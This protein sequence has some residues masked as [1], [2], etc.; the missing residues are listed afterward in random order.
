VLTQTA[1]TGAGTASAQMHVRV[2]VLTSVHVPSDTRIYHRECKALAEAGYAVT[3]VA[4]EGIDTPLPGVASLALGRARGRAARVAVTTTRAMAAALRLRARIVHLQ[5]PELVPVG[6]LLR[7]FGRR[8]IY[9]VHEDYPQRVRHKPYLASWQRAL[10]PPVVTGMEWAAGR[11]FSAV[12]AATPEIAARFPSHQCVTVQNFPEIGELGD[13]ATGDYAK[14]APR[15]AYVGDLTQERGVL[16]AIDAIARCRTPGARLDLAGPVSCP[17]VRRR[18]DAGLPDNVTLH[19]RLGRPAVRELLARAR[20]GLVL[21][22]PLPGYDVSWPVKLFE[23]MAAG[24]PTVAT[25][26]ASWRARFADIGSIRFVDP[27]DPGAVAAAIDDLLA[28]PQAARAAGEAGRTAMRARY[29]WEREREK[30]LD[31]Y[32]KLRD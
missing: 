32:A 12:V 6:L 29:S 19:G 4:Q 21:L 24:L 25:D 1:D 13:I 26:F 9:D 28:D 7:L 8:V 5:D 23:Y 22:H 18:I 11:L 20:V 2:A 31:L 15:V 17:A 16:A 10:F 30:L 3:L 14:R 27:R